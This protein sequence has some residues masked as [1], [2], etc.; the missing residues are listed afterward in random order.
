MQK[1]EEQDGFDGDQVRDSP[2]DSSFTEGE[3]KSSLKG[4]DKEEMLE[5]MMET[6][7]KMTADLIETSGCKAG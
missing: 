3:E 6:S 2:S 1:K 7:K 4:T 5:K